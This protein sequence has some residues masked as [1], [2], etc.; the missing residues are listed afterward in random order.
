MTLYKARF[1]NY[2][3]SL[4]LIAMPVALSLILP[5]NPSTTE[6]FKSHM[7]FCRIC[8]VFSMQRTL[9]HLRQLVKIG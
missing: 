1:E 5:F 7:R 6:A 3:I 9:L 4:A 8:I 2:V